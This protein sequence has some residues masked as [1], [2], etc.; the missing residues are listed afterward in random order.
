MS[1]KL[2]TRGHMPPLTV[3]AP[4]LDCG[5]APLPEARLPSDASAIGRLPSRSWGLLCGP[6]RDCLGPSHFPQ[7]PL[8]A[9]TSGAT[10]CAIAIVAH[11]AEVTA[12]CHVYHGGWRS[13][14]WRAGRPS[15]CNGAQVGARDGVDRNSEP[16]RGDSMPEAEAGGVVGASGGPREAALEGGNSEEDSD[17]RPAEEREVEEQAQG[18]N[19]MMVSRH[20]PMSGF[21][22]TVLNLVHS[23]VN[24][25]SD[26]HV[27]LLPNDDHVLVWHQTRPRLS[28]HG[29]AAVAG[30]SEVQ[31]PLDV[32]GEGPAEEAPD[33]GRSRRRKPR[34]PRHPRRPLYGR[35]PPRS[36]RSPACGRCHRSLSPLRK[37]LNA[38]M[39]TPKKRRRAPKVRGKKRSIT[40]N[41]KNQ[42]RI[43][44][45]Q[46]TGPES[47]VWKTR[48]KTE[49]EERIHCSLFLDFSE[50]HGN[51]IYIDFLPKSIPQ[52]ATV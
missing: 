21:S 9:A 8:R 5:L 6:F 31:V 46:R 13:D 41:K 17:I 42:K 23:M 26:N 12:G 1:P 2:V 7:P 50:A 45:Q 48:K 22:L 14:P 47:P 15:R 40:E 10:T 44:T 3:P 11:P 52:K 29:S 35:R 16:R 39:R 24:R 37:Q 25:L 19:R 27:I 51:I 33:Q 34:R 4:P 28:D 38:R 32:S 43:W 36:L 18:V 49:K 20:F 30:L